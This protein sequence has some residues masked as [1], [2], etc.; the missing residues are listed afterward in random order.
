MVVT[1]IT[2][3][4]ASVFDDTIDS[5]GRRVIDTTNRIMDDGTRYFA[6]DTLATQQKLIDCTHVN[7]VILLN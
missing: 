6:L 1:G 4:G 3:D 7:R 2:T 5:R